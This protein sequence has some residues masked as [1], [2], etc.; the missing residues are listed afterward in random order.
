MKA[1]VAFALAVLVAAVVASAIGNLRTDEDADPPAVVPATAPP[2][3]TTTAGRVTTSAGGAP[4]PS[5]GVPA[6]TAVPITTTVVGFTK[7]VIATHNSSTSCWL[8]IAGRVY[9][10]TPYLRNHPGGSRTI[11]PWCGK[12]STQA[13]ATED[14]RGEHSPDA[15]AQLKPFDIGAL[16]AG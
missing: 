15:Y 11:L 1:L 16:V 8:L 9:D 13:F 12:E 6:T 4:T 14:G 10:V 7:A 3:S 5:S 2:A